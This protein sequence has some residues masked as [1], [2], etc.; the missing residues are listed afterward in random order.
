M[1]V[2]AREDE[3][4]FPGAES[5]RLE[6]ESLGLGA[7]N[8]G[9]GD[10]SAIVRFCATC[11]SL[12]LDTMSTG[13]ATAFTMDCAE[14]GLIDSDL[15]FGDSRGQVQLAMDIAHRKG[16]GDTL[17]HGVRHAAEAWGV[18]DSEVPVMEVKGLEYPAFEPRSSVGMALAIATSDR[19]ACHCRAFP[20]ANE[21]L[22]SDPDA[23]P[24]GASG[25]AAMVMAEQ[26]QKTADWCLVTC[27]FLEYGRS[28]VLGMLAAIGMEMTN[29]EYQRMGA[30][31]WNLVR[32]I[33]VREGWTAIDDTMPPALTRPLLDT[34]RRLDRAPL[35]A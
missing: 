32:L 17:A 30:R 2:R 16:L 1:H 5:R 4:A 22:S 9:N 26:D 29:D 23:D 12:G 18:D 14:R 8:T 13:V 20:V 15:R 11:D 24:F 19:G 10:F 7:S 27:D 35:K 34:G 31:I 25:K 6:Y 33:N 21:A 28:E 3:G